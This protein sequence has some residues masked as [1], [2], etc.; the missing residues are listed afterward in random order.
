MKKELVIIKF[1]SADQFCKFYKTIKQ[2]RLFLPLSGSMRGSP[3][4]ILKLII[5]LIEP[6]FFST[7][8]PLLCFL[9]N[10]PRL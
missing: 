9:A 1:T 6:V 10:M 7:K 8:S 2:G 3:H 4:L 5:P